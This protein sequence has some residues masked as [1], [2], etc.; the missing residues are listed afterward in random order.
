[1]LSILLQAIASDYPY[2]IFWPLC[3]LF[4]FKPWL[5]I[6]IM[7]SSRISY[8]RPLVIE[9]TIDFNLICE[10]PMLKLVIGIKTEYLIP[11]SI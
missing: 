8:N 5:L 2:D 4:F 1:V 9:L 6:T 7:I 11:I 3:C 10:S